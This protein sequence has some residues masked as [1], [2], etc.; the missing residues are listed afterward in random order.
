MTRFLAE[1]QEEKLPQRLNADNP[2]DEEEAD[3][4]DNWMGRRPLVHDR[5]GDMLQLPDGQ[6]RKLIPMKEIM[7]SADAQHNAVLK[8][9]WY[10]KETT[11]RERVLAK[12][13]LDNVEELIKDIPL[14]CKHFDLL[15]VQRAA[16]LAM[17]SSMPV[18][19]FTEVEIPHESMKE[20]TR[21]G[22]RKQPFSVKYNIEAGA[23]PVFTI[24][25]VRYAPPFR[26]STP[27]CS[28]PSCTSA[29]LHRL[30]QDHHGNHGRAHD[31]L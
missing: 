16:V 1:A 15:P 19:T 25:D 10:V 26:S 8:K 29:V 22:A 30:G 28:Q 17:T 9:P 27:L 7:A 2:V 14:R 20:I 24:A 12:Y 31:A 13:L 21:S 18:E 23:L 6:D 11:N 4:E 5:V 3:Y